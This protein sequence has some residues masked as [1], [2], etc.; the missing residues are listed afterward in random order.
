MYV[1]TTVT[2]P[3]SP[4]ALNELPAVNETTAENPAVRDDRSVPKPNS[5][6]EHTEF[7]S[8]QPTA[9]RESSLPLRVRLLLP[10]LVIAFFAVKLLSPIRDPDTFWHL[11]TGDWLRETGSFRGRD[12]WSNSSTNEWVL[13]E[14]LPQLA[15]SWVQQV[16]GLAG[17]AWLHSASIVALGIALWVATRR[18]A[19]LLL[20]AVVMTLALL[21]MSGSLSPRPQMITFI[22]TV[23]TVDAWLNSARDGRARWWLIP[24]TWVWACS[25][26]MWFIGVLVGLVT[27][28]GIALDRS[29]STRAALRLALVPMGSVLVAALTPAGPSLLASP[30]HVSAYTRFVDEWDPATIRDVPFV[31]FLVVAA[32]VILVWA[33]RG[34]RV[35]WV[36]LLVASSAVG[37][38]LMYARTVA[39]GAA[40]LAPI[41]AETLQVATGLAR[42]RFTRPEA[43]V[44]GALATTAL[45]LAAVLAPLRASEPG[46]GPTGMNGA[47]SS[48]PQGTVVCNDYGLGG[49]LIWRHSGLRPAIDGRTEIYAVDYMDLYVKFET[50]APGWQEF[51]RRAGCSHALLPGDLPVVEALE[52][53][54]MWRRAAATD[55]YVLLEAPK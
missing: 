42:E 49:W 7:D 15:L 10:G 46:L 45:A 39:V 34:G 26:G 53:R 40:I 44:V 13:H 50:A 12:P 36:H 1:C 48:L 41:A 30:F 2:L 5:L 23:V 29:V 19:S 43:R 47:L 4:S 52:Q 54:L 55:G 8:A 33:R 38:A 28:G 35:Q 11:A 22:L 32:A 51:A 31:A 9:P 25:H 16:F 17:V 37:F 24:M 21:G 14:W 20:S 3:R 18:R 27:L 6:A